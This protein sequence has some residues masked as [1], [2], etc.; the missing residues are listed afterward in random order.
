MSARSLRA[1]VY[2]SVRR[3][4]LALAIV[5]ELY[6]LAFALTAI[7]VRSQRLFRAER[8]YQREP[9]TAAA[10]HYAL[11]RRCVMQPLWTAQAIALLFAILLPSGVLWAKH[12]RRFHG[13]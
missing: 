13:Q 9:S 11:M 5:C 10:T 7:P 12:R 1:F 2:A 3:C 4:A 6:L 8:A